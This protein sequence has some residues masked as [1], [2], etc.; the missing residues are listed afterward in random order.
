M[1]NLVLSVIGEN[2]PYSEIISGC[3]IVDKKVNY[4]FELWLKKDICR[5]SDEKTDQLKSA[6]AKL[7]AVPVNL[8]NISRHKKS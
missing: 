4:K 6:F 2:L 1:D 5:S 3:R 8:L 7:F